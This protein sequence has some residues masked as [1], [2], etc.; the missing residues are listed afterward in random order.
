[1]RLTPEGRKTIQ[2]LFR[3]HER[4]ME[5]AAARLS[6]SERAELMRLLR[7]LGKDR[8]Q[9]SA[10]SDQSGRPRKAE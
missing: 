3:T 7:K 10:V 9:R 8:V 2:A 1:V 4:D 5:Q 6:H